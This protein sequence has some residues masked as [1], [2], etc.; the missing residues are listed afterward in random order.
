MGD[1]ALVLRQTLKNKL[2]NQWQ[3]PYPIT[4]IVTPVTYL[5]DVGG[6]GNKYWT[7]HVNCMMKWNS[8]STSV[9]LAEEEEEEEKLG[10]TEKDPTQNMPASK[11]MDLIKFK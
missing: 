9:F 6:K 2:L 7:Y 10:K 5:V 11:N 1:F 3:G 4:E 8:P